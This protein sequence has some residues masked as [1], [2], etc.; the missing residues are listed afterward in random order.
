MHNSVG[1][2][3][4]FGQIRGTVES[5]SPRFLRLRHHR[6]AVHTVPFGEIRWLTNQSRDW[7]IM[8]L[9][10]RVPFETDLRLVKKLVREIGEELMQDEEIGPWLLE[11]I[12]SRGVIRME[13]FCMVVGVKITARPGDGVFLVRREA[14]H[15]ILEAFMANG[16]RFADRHLKV[17][18]LAGTTE[19][20][21]PSLPGAA[22]AAIVPMPAALASE[23]ETAYER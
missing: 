14:Y 5:I 23:R 1:E 21:V 11:P 16:I 8:K 10:F 18:L 20:P 7:Q 22:E 9:E 4:E 3:V 2:Y 13:E 12:K 17:E 15:R 6:G 19:T